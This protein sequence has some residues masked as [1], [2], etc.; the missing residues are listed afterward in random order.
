ML[1][2][3][4][5]NV[6]NGSYIFMVTYLHEWA[7]QLITEISETLSMCLVNNVLTCFFN[8]DVTGDFGA[9]WLSRKQII[10]FYL[11]PIITGSGSKWKVAVLLSRKSNKKLSVFN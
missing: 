11:R 4:L 2:E 5:H 7:G 6:M 3:N 10:L 1:N 9:R 8:W